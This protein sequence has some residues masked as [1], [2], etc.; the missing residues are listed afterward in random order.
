MNYFLMLSEMWFLPAD[1]KV[2]HYEMLLNGVVFFS[3]WIL[4]N[5]CN[6]F[7]YCLGK[8]NYLDFRFIK[9]QTSINCLVSLQ[10]CWHVLCS[11]LD[12][13]LLTV[14]FITLLTKCT[15]IL[16]V[17]RSCCL[18]V[19]LVGYDSRIRLSRL[20]KAFEIFFNDAIFTVCL[21]GLLKN[22]L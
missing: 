17:A 16:L 7:I 14:F 11:R 21:D 1:V 8:Y 15:K 22:F 3:C 20:T 19:C 18:T 13:T 10:R 12:G 6:A 9:T 5:V 4:D 2:F